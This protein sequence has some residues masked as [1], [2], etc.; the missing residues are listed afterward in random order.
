MILTVDKQVKPLK[1][2]VPVYN[3]KKFN[4]YI[5]ENAVRVHYK[6]QPVIVVWKNNWSLV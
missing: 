1:I 4:S 5:T 2:Y 6:A 3:G